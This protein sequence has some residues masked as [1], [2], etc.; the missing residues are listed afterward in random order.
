M[1]HASRTV[2]LEE[3]WR[4]LASS[5][6]K[7]RR[8]VDGGGEGLSVEENMQTYTTVYC[9][10]KQ[11]APHNYSQQLYQRY[12][13]DL[14]DYIKSTTSRNV[15]ISVLGRASQV[16]PTLKEMHGEVLLRGLLDR[17]RKHSR[18]LDSEIKLFRY[19]HRYYISKTSLPPLK[20][21]GSTSFRDLVFNEFKSTVTRTVISMIDDER[22]GQPTD[23]DLLMNVLDIYVQIC[24]GKLDAY[25]ADFEQP[26]LEGTR[27]YVSRKAQA[28]I[29]EY[30]DPEYMLKVEECCAIGV[31]NNMRAKPDSYLKENSEVLKKTACWN[32][33]IVFRLGIF[34]R[35]PFSYS[36]V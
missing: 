15:W 34:S 17:W 11:A 2:E 12:K 20:Q 14:D 35:K 21:L 13:D 6:A 22:E 16:L 8:A 29:H 27:N 7:I 32:S 28:W 9:M 33:N 30:S 23:R 3:G 24:S 26:F 19:L 31:D 18:I 4:F 10:C 25:K 5:L 1:E 36:R